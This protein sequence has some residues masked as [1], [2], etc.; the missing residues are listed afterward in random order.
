MR[1]R[2]ELIM[3]GKKACMPKWIEISKTSFLSHMHRGRSKTTVPCCQI[4][5]L[6]CRA[7]KNRGGPLQQ[8]L[9]IPL[10][11]PAQVGLLFTVHLIRLLAPAQKW[12]HASKLGPFC[13][14]AHGETRAPCHGYTLCTVYVQW[15]VMGLL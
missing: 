3:I 10:T 8:S 12:F 1:Y 2:C 5:V 6:K 7:R 4:K 15:N 9:Q 11:L 13:H 14:E